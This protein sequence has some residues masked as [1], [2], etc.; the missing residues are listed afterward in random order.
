MTKPDHLKTFET[1]Q[2][3]WGIA[4]SAA[5]RERLLKQSVVDDCVYQD[6][7]TE[8]HGHA[9]LI[10]KIEDASQ[11]GPG[12]TFRNDRFFEHHDKAVIEWTMFDGAGDEFAQGASYV[13]FAADGRLT[14]MTGFYDPP[15]RAFGKTK[16]TGQ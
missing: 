13:Q 2:S 5:D 12:A 1:Y 9:E 4:V 10:A 7:G 11:K 8:C 6:P 14:T 3:A 16:A 15:T